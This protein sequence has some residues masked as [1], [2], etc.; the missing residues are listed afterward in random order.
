M[1]PA[2]IF[3]PQPELRRVWPNVRE[4][5]AKLSEA[6]RHE[7]IPEDVYRELSVGGTYLF[8][9]PD[10]RAFLITQILVSPYAREL[11][12]WAASNEWAGDRL[13]FFAQLKSIAAENECTRITWNSDR[14]GWE[15]AIPG[16]RATTRYSFE[17]GE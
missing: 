1:T 6:D 3:V 8:T 14:T 17:M 5:L 12:V 10:F 13:D 16:V 7:W 11:H 4:A 15:R 2:L 9:S